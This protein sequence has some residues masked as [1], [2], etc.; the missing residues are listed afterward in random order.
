MYALLTYDAY[1]IQF[2]KR[3]VERYLSPESGRSTTMFFPLF[4]SLA[5]TIAAALRAAPDEI[6]TR[7]PSDTAKFLPSA[8]ASSFSIAIT[9]S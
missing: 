5:A 2:A 9:S 3:G 8:N 4:S 7:I 1:I 6:P